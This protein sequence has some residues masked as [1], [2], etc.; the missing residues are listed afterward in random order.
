MPGVF[1]RAFPKA[2]NGSGSDYETE[3]SFDYAFKERLDR[4]GRTITYFPNGADPKDFEALVYS[5]RK[6]YKTND[7]GSEEIIVR[8]VCFFAN[9]SEGSENVLMHEKFTVDGNTYVST[10]TRLG[11]HTWKV[12]LKRVK[13]MDIARPNRRSKG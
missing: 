8:D 13:S 11:I 7:H 9:D 2:I 3:D 6:E 1:D 5:E 4:F 12:T 10:T